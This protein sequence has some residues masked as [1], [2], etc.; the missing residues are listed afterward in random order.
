MHVFTCQLKASA[1]SLLEILCEEIH[2]KTKENV[3]AIAT[4]VD[5]ITL[6]ETMYDCYLLRNNTDHE[7]AELACDTAIKTHN[8][9]KHMED[10]DDIKAGQ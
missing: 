3:I 9:L 8:L 10:F 1:I 2:P 4:Y 6:H 7:I 5:V